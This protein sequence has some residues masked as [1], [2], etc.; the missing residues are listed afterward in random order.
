MDIKS[1]WEQQSSSGKIAG[2]T[3]ALF[4]TALLARSAVW[5]VD[6]TAALFYEQT[7]QESH[8]MERLSALLQALLLD[9]FTVGAV[10][11]AVLILVGPP[12]ARKAHR[13]WKVADAIRRL[14]LAKV[15]K[16]KHLAH[17]AGKASDLARKCMA[18]AEYATAVDYSIYIS[19]DLSSEEVRA[20]MDRD[21][22]ERTKRFQEAMAE[23]NETLFLPCRAALGELSELGYVGKLPPAY[24]HVV[25]MFCI[26]DLAC[27]LNE[28][29]AAVE[30]DLRRRGFNL[31]RLQ[32]AG[33][34]QQP[35]IG[36]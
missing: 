6:K 18:L 33:H 12:L 15:G 29:A 16:E 34:Q 4:A 20:R 24:E 32:A 7:L 31:D 27:S 9:R 10:T 30:K 26:K 2:G 22:E 19:S 17:L 11:L 25:N 3:L 13:F 23:F 1:W 21:A 14:F 28:G 5:L 8:A 36:V 35:D